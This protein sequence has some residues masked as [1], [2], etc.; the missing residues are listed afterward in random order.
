MVLIDNIQNRIVALAGPGNNRRTIALFCRGLIVYTLLKIV[1][2][3][4]LIPDVLSGS[5]F[6]I[7]TNPLAWLLFLPLRVAHVNVWIF[8]VGVMIV[9]VT[10]LCLRPNYITGIVLFVIVL[11]LFRFAISVVNGSDFVLLMLCVW[12]IALPVYPVGKGE[13]IQIIQYAASNVSVILIQIQVVLIYWVSGW[14]KLLSSLWRSGDAF[15]YVRHLEFMFNPGLVSIADG[16]E[17]NIFLSWFTIVFE[18]TFGVLVW[19]KR[20]RPAM[21]VLGVLFHLGIALMLNLPD[22]MLIMTLSYLCFLRDSDYD[23]L[24]KVFIRSPR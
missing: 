10:S 18:L 14:D 21:L 3:A 5:G 19:F 12:A 2:Y 4:L 9:L 15:V 7:P 13:K 8:L 17:L 16:P 11:N 20:T 6:S 23:G 1:L 24:R 22:F